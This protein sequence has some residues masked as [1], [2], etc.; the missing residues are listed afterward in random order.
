MPGRKGVVQD[1]ATKAKKPGTV[2]GT[3]DIV[4]PITDPTRMLPEVSKYSRRSA[5]LE[6]QQAAMNL[7]SSGSVIITPLTPEQATA[8]GKMTPEAQEIYRRITGLQFKPGIA[9]DMARKDAAIAF[10]KLPQAEYRAM[11]EAKLQDIRPDLTRQGSVVYTTHTP[12]SLAQG[13]SIGS[14][15]KGADK[16]AELLAKMQA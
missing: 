14:T 8:L 6:K 15:A 10:S 1:I 3:D 2:F 16:L 7:P 4:N 12:E 11:A 13:Y 9:K 5:A